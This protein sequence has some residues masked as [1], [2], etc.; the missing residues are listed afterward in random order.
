MDVGAT[1]TALTSKAQPSIVC[2]WCETVG[3]PVGGTGIQ[4]WLNNL[5]YREYATVAVVAGSVYGLG[6]P[7]LFF[8]VVHNAKGQRLSNAFEKK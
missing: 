3:A 4:G 1:G 8:F 5:E 7:I 6:V 2:Q